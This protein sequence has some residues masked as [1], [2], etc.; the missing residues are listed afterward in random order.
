MRR[1]MA[2]LLCWTSVGRGRRTQTFSGSSRSIHD[3]K[4]GHRRVTHLHSDSYQ[5]LQKSRSNAVGA[6]D[7][8]RPKAFAVLLLMLDRVAAFKTFFT[9][10]PHFSLS[11]GYAGH[12]R[13]GQAERVFHRGNSAVRM[14]ETEQVMSPFA[15]DGA[16]EKE[17][18]KKSAGS[19]SLTEENVEK[20]LDE[21]RPYLLADGG[22]V[23]LQGIK[24]GVVSLQFEGACSSCASSSITLRMGLEKGLREKIPEIVSIQEVSGPD[25]KP[26]GESGI[27]E[28]LN[29]IRP[30]LKAA[31]GTITIASSD[32][33]AMQPSVTLCLTG[34]A[35]T[36]TSVRGEIVARIKRTFPQLWDVKFAG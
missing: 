6:N 1:G 26:L 21:M 15:Q 8:H 5:S 34:S 14:A 17:E 9:A 10:G 3:A 23:N 30:F 7:I 25:A 35:A 12:G 27:E 11:D 33:D 29:G 28:V 18:T 36:I 32:F 24:D 20:V 19:L 4:Y 22:N 2:L 31:G 13:V 16:E